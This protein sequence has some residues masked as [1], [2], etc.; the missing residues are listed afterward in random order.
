MR[1]R[2]LLAAMSAGS[3][4]IAG[5]IGDSDAGGTETEPTTDGGSDDPGTDDPGTT[6]GTTEQG[7]PPLDCPTSQNLDV[8][9][10]EGLDSSTVADFVEAYEAAYY[11]EVVVGYDPESPF[12]SYELSGRVVDGP[13]E[14]GSGWVVEYDGSGAVYR[15]SL[16]FNATT[17]DPPA[18]ANVVPA[19]EIDDATITTVVEAAAESGEGEKHVRDGDE[20]GRYADLLPSLSEDV[21]D[22]SEQGD[23][24][25]LDVVVDGTV[26]KLTVS[27]GNFHGDYWWK[28][29][30]YVDERVVRRAEGGDADPREG[31]LLECRTDE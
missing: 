22:L 13:T 30:Y 16:W 26:V 11:R 8:E 12:A 27:V 24:V 6:D 7:D 2:T 28:A 31:T 14:A 21:G 19:A 20:A 29:N 9:W 5:C 3:L 25:S 10:P 4:A 17:A 15:G 1:R 23:E 18:E